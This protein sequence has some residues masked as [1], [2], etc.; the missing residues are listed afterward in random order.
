MKTN[1]KKRSL[2]MIA[3][4]GAVTSL[5]LAGGCSEA[6]ATVDAGND[7]GTG[8]AG[9][10]A[11]LDTKRPKD[12]APPD[13]QPMC[14]TPGDVSK[15][16]PP[17]LVPPRPATD[18]CGPT[19]AQGYWDACRGA[20]ATQVGCAAWKGANATCAGCIESQRADADWGALVMANGITF[21]NVSGCIALLGDVPCAKAYQDASLCEGAS[22]DTM[23]AVTD[24]FDP[25]HVSTLASW[26]KCAQAAAST[27]CANYEKTV[28]SSCVKDAGTAAAVCLSF[29]SFMGGYFQYV[30]MF[31][32]AGG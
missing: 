15:F 14:P 20:Q 29:T 25:D 19:L 18:S 23:C 27:V 24:F 21:L 1:R 13:S 28:A 32:S 2:V 6:P 9:A 3:L 30:S 26:Q 17:A 4:T 7:A 11:A 12:T 31:C 16:V 10:D 8:E 5:S 22:C